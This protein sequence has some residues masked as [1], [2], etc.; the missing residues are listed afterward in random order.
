MSKLC[1]LANVLFV[2]AI[3]AT[4]AL[5]YDLNGV[6]ASDADRCGKIFTKS[7]KQISFAKMADLYGSGFI[8]DSSSLRGKTARCTVKSRRETQDALH[9]LAS[10]STDIMLSN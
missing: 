9:I 2:A 1:H 3:V 5:A 7:G 8:V 4:P 6:W 10:C